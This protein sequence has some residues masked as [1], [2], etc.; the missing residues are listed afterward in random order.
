MPAG[1]AVAA[2]LAGCQSWPR[3]TL[4]I[5]T[6]HADAGEMRD[7]NQTDDWTYGAAIDGVVWIDSMGTRHDS[8]RPHVSRPAS[9]A[10]SG[11]R[12]SR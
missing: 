7:L 10:R 11:S 12:P 4:E 8:G 6:G 3:V 2:L 9:A 1:V 5:Q